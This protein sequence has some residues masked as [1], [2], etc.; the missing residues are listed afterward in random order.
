MEYKT[1][2]GGKGDTLGIEQKIQIWSYKQMVYVQT[3]I[4]PR[5]WD[6]KNSQGI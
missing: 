6:A 5:E 4:H 1:R 3:T 2:L